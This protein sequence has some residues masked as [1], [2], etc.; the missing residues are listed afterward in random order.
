MAGSGVYLPTMED[1]MDATQLALPWDAE[2]NQMALYNS[3]RVSA[4]NFNSDTVYSSTNE[5]AGMTGYT[6]KGKAVTGTAFSRPGSAVMKFSSSAVA[7]AGSTLSGVA[8]VELFAE[9]V[10]GDPLMMGFDLDDS[11]NTSDGT[12]TLTPHTNGL[13]SVGWKPA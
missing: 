7:W 9:A 10:S 11:I 3:T 1:L 6:A 5:L 12:L 4:A 13:L 2:D 8:W